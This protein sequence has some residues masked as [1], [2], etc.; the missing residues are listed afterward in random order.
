VLRGQ[1]ERSCG[2]IPYDGFAQFD[3]SLSFLVENSGVREELGANGQNYV[4]ESY[5]W[6][7]VL[8]HVASTIEIAQQR[9]LNRQHR[10]AR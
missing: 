6:P 9:F 2:A 7:V 10:F 4:R 1:A 3:E 5:S 8:E